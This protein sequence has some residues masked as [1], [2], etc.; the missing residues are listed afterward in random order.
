MIVRLS[1]KIVATSLRISRKVRWRCDV[2]GR[3]LMGGLLVPL[4][5]RQRRTIQRWPCLRQF[6]KHFDQSVAPGSVS[7]LVQRPLDYQAALVQQAEAIAQ[8]FGLVEPVRGEDDSLA[9]LAQVG[10]E[11]GHD[12]AAQDVQAQRR[13]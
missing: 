6:E 8:P 4:T 11:L 9:L 10:N 7:Q 2:A 1:R 3:S 12:L 13:L 5:R